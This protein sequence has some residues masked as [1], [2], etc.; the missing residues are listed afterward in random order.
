V[1]RIC[2]YVKQTQPLVIKSGDVLA[3]LEQAS[4]NL[5]ISHSMNAEYCNPKGIRISI[6]IY[7]GDLLELLGA[8]YF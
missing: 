1:T 7:S 4:Q 8:Q 3:S 5:D 6:L 2:G